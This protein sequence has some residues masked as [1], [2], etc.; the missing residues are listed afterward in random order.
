MASGSDV[1]CLVG[2]PDG[3]PPWARSSSE[4]VALAGQTANVRSSMRGRRRDQCCR[5]RGRA[6]AQAGRVA[7]GAGARGSSR[8]MWGLSVSVSCTHLRAHET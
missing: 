2:P 7:R 3:Q 1:E 4:A 5:R 8:A 6:G